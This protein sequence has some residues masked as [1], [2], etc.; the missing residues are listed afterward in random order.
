MSKLAWFVFRSLIIIFFLTATT[1]GPEPSPQAVTPVGASSQSVELA[2]TR[3]L[4]SVSTSTSTSTVLPSSP[5]PTPTPFVE[6]KN[7]TVVQY[8][9][10]VLAG[11]PGQIV[12]HTL[13]ITNMSS[14]NKA[15]D[16]SI[17][18]EPRREL[19][20]LGD[21]QYDLRQDLFKTYYFHI[22]P[23]QSGEVHIPV[24]IPN[25]ATDGMVN[26]L[27]VRISDHHGIEGPSEPQFTTAV[28]APTSIKLV[29]QVD[30]SAQDI[31]VRGNYA[32]V[33]TGSNGLHVLDVTDPTK[34]IEIADYSQLGA[35]WHVAAQENYIYTILVNHCAIPT[36]DGSFCR[37]SALSVLD[38]SN[39]TKPLEV[40][41]YNLPEY[42]Y[43]TEGFENKESLF[44]K[45]EIFDDSAYI[46]ASQELSILDISDPT[47][48]KKTNPADMQLEDFYVTDAYLYVVPLNSYNFDDGAKNSY[49]NILDR[50][51]LVEIGSYH[52]PNTSPAVEVTVINHTAYV[53]TRIPCVGVCE[54]DF[55]GWFVLDV[56][57]PANPVEITQTEPTYVTLSIFNPTDSV[58]IYKPL[59]SQ[60]IAFVD[61]YAYLADGKAGLRVLDISSPEQPPVERDAFGAGTDAFNLEVSDGYI[62]LANGEGGLSILQDTS[63]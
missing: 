1:C 49:L 43:P 33:A 15:Y 41:R 44:H 17:K 2:S 63:P 38:V 28:S 20:I 56:S 5:T 12:T 18:M 54:S 52:L 35:T 7:E 40:G 62:Y 19:A 58:E 39:P 37:D 13:V 10:S 50:S 25:K 61:D 53:R 29:S 55:Y 47:G 23:Q 45:L 3:L 24:G 36:T 22:E 48:L 57:D 16:V 4:T 21:W 27:F 51:S 11:Q 26:K 59:E 9:T 42:N 30:I 34:P 6:L 46:K 8:L 31:A 32:F 14:T 60:D